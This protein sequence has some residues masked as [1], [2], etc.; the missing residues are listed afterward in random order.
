MSDHSRTEGSHLIDL[1]HISANCSNSNK[2]IRLYG[3]LGAAS[4]LFKYELSCA[5]MA[6]C[7]PVPNTSL[8][9]CSKTSETHAQ[10]SFT[11]NTCMHV[12]LNK[13]WLAISTFS[14]WC[15]ESLSPTEL[16]HTILTILTLW[17]HT[18]THTHTHTHTHNF[19][20][21]IMSS[22]TLKMTL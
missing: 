17:V 5:N 1:F 11:I 12:H 19:N 20:L 21:Q 7:Q 18:N 22:C 9:D 10:M 3:D 2:P 14:K 13:K 8:A 15:M 16:K 4:I 6:A